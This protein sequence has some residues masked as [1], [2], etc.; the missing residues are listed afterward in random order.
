MLSREA[1][2]FVVL[3]VPLITAIFLSIRLI[4]KHT[5]PQD[6]SQQLRWI[7]PASPK[8]GSRPSVKDA[9]VAKHIGHADDDGGSEITA[10]A[11]PQQHDE[12][13]PSPPDTPQ[14]VTSQTAP[15]EL[16]AKL[17]LPPPLSTDPFQGASQAVPA[18]HVVVSSSGELNPVD[19]AA[20]AAGAG[21]AM[22]FRPL[23]FGG[24][25]TINPNVLPHP[26]KR[27]TYVMVAQEHPPPPDS[28]GT[29]TELTCDAALNRRGELACV[30]FPVPLAIEPT[31]TKGNNAC[32]DPTKPG[33]ELLQINRGPHD[34][35]VFFGPTGGDPLVSYGSNSGFT[36]FGQ[37]IQDFCAV[38]RWGEQQQQQQLDDGTSAPADR[39]FARGTEMQRPAGDG[40]SAVEKN[41]FVFWD[42]DGVA[43]AHHAMHPR[44]VLGRLGADGS[45]GRDLGR[46]TAAADG[47]CMAR[48]L[49]NLDRIPWPVGPGDEDDSIHQSTN[50]LAV[51]LCRRADAG[52]RPG[53]DNTFVATVV[54][55]KRYRSFRS[56]Y[57]AYVVLFRQEAPFAL[58]AVSRR[59]LWIS[60]RR[61]T[62][63]R[64][65]MFYI[66]SLNW[67]RPGQGYHGYL[68][69]V[70][71]AGFGIEDERSA[72]LD[73]RAGD[74]F[75]D[76][77]LC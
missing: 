27:D 36:C 55:H 6:P 32:D 39:L 57:E 49:P 21:G 59:P 26:T 42:R 46:D 35:R 56:S 73:V 16:G 3:Y 45:V 30:T 11:L 53:P 69:D 58:H 33:L 22:P 24:R 7:H 19:A 40:Y 44:R 9:A 72:V 76:L 2:R 68:D 60:G 48:H 18:T 62:A 1:R 14:M 12:K 64:T 74:L 43:H 34:A 63:E 54:Q 51:T 5:T 50:S 75:Q 65:E 61:T 10:A 4:R 66:T 52:C 77:G 17:L 31:R 41:F 15:E 70:V 67:M 23:V 38:S 13:A 37:W 8:W 71:L 25:T 20:K 28:F 47:A 29:F